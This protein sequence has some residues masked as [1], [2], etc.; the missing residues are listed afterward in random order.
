MG[1]SVSGNNAET[2]GSVL[3]VT[4]NQLVTLFIRQHEQRVHVHVHL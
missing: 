2:V 3:M 1:F 4:L